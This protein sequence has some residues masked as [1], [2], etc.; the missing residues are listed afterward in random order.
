MT[1]KPLLLLLGLPSELVKSKSQ[2]DRY[3][4]IVQLDTTR[5]VVDV[6]HNAMGMY[7]EGSKQAN[8]YCGLANQQ[9]NN[10][11]DASLEGDRMKPS[12]SSSRKRWMQSQDFQSVP[13]TL[14]QQMG[15][16]VPT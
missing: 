2:P 12:V 16:G 11:S 10:S 13:L 9:S 4:N 7:V 5:Y 15:T 1:L 6:L 14:L 3:W 8:R